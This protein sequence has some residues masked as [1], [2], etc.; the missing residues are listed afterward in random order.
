MAAAVADQR[1]VG[2]ADEAV[3]AAAV[4]VLLAGERAVRA[5]E[6]SAPFGVEERRTHWPTPFG[7]QTVGTPSFIGIPSACG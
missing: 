6:S 3:H 1:V 7:T 2:D 5:A 4:D